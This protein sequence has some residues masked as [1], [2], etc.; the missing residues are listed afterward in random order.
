MKIT[1]DCLRKD[2]GHKLTFEQCNYLLALFNRIKEEQYHVDLRLSESCLFKSFVILP[3]VLPPELTPSQIFAHYLSL[4]NFL[5]KDKEVL[6]MGCGSGIQGLTMLNSGASNAVFTDLST[7]ASENT[8]KN[9]KHFNY[10][11]K[12]LV[13]NGNLFDNIKQKFDLIFFNHP[14]FSCKPID[15]YPMAL[16]VFDEGLLI[17]DFLKNAPIYLKKNGV[18]V[19]PF[20]SLGSEENDPEIQAK[21]YHYRV[22]RIILNSVFVQNKTPQY[23]INIL[24]K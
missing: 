5:F 17:Q 20:F 1:L 10:Q 15:K 8:E 21:K 22:K 6:D 3:T 13:V 2:A 14:F 18:I 16:S 12:S 9:I 4:N 11:E 23:S 24:Y 7:I 19:M